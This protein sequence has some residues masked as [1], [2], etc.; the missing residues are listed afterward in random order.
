[1]Q[2]VRTGSAASFRHQPDDD[3]RVD[4]AG[5]KRPQR[6]VAL[7]SHLDRRSQQ[8]P[9]LA[10]ILFGRPIV[11]D[12]EVGLPVRPYVE[13]P[14]APHGVVTRRK[15]GD[16]LENRPR[17][18]HVLIREVFVEGLRV[19][20]PRHAR[21]LQD[22][23]EFAGKQQP[24]RLVTINQRLLP[25]PIAGQHQLLPPGVPDGQGK[26]AVKV[27]NEFWPV[28]F[29]EMD[30]H[31]GVA[32]SAEAMPGPF[33]SAAEV[34]EV[35]DFAVENDPHGAVF[36]RQW[37]FAAG[38]VDDRQPP[39]AQGHAGLHLTGAVEVHAFAVRP[40][41]TQHVDHP[42]ERCLPQ[43]LVGFIPHRAG[44]TAHETDNRRLTAA[45]QGQ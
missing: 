24:A 45:K 2:N 4:P 5:E 12:V 31:F 29:V 9:Q 25:Q 26:H 33:Q 18:R 14:L 23:L 8:L 32:L 10:A 42:L 38:E 6:H 37:L 36:V 34:A 22:A 44:D 15:L 43:G 1:M 7:Q 17:M 28:V 11:L 35:I 41:M 39:M 19:D 16:A 20:L 27:C 21:H 30:Q 40:T 13:P 3:R